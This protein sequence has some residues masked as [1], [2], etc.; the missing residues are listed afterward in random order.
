MKLELIHEPSKGKA[1]STPLLFI[2]GMWHGAWCWQEY[3]LPYFTQNGYDAYALSLR[4]HAGSEGH[5]GLRWHSISDYAK[6]VEWAVSQIGKPAVIIGHSMGGYV[7]QKYLETH[8]APAAVL[9]NSVPT[10]TVWPATFRVLA[11]HPW[12]VIK[13]IGTLK[14]YPVIETP[15]LAQFALFSKDMPLETVKK[16]QAIMQNESFR[17]YVDMLGIN[18]IHASRVKTPLLVIGAAEDAVIGVSD[19][20][21]TAK[22]HHTEAVILPNMAHDVML[23]AN[24]KSVADKVLEWM[25]ARGL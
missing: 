9:L 1:K 19:V 8:D 4:G 12:A 6:D 13:A 22:A 10:V 14:M 21:A 2:H 17:A 11:K 25:T 24:W 3:F 18:L 15:A 20:R 16:Y 23:E 5:E 7:T